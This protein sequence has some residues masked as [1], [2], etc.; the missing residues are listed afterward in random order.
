MLRGDEPSL[1][2]SFARKN[3]TDSRSLL[4]G[5]SSSLA[6]RREPCLIGLPPVL[7]SISPLYYDSGWLDENWAEVRQVVHGIFAFQGMLACLGVLVGFL[8][9]SREV[10]CGGF[11]RSG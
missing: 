8:E 7:P 9:R 1:F 6:R 4:A 5:V 11:G 3:V 10:R 2:F